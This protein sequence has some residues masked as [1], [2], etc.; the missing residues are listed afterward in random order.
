MKDLLEDQ[1][2]ENVIRFYPPELIAMVQAVDPELKELIRNAAED[3]D[4][5]AAICAL[6]D[7]VPVQL[8]SAPG[9]AD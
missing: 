6:V 7:S 8:D 2:I 9:R 1:Y 5:I 4:D 3:S